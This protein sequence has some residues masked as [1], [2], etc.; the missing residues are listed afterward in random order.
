MAT[1]SDLADACLTDHQDCHLLVDVTTGG[2]IVDVRAVELRQPVE[3]EGL[4]CLA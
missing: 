4:Q 1:I 3:V 2:E